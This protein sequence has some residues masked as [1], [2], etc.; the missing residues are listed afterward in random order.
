M[1]AQEVCLVPAVKHRAKEHPDHA[2][3]ADLSEAPIRGKDLPAD[4]A[5]AIG[6]DSLRKQV[7][8]GEESAFIKAAQT[9]KTLAIKEHEHACGER[10]E[11][12]TYALH[13]VAAEV[14]RV[15]EQISVTAGDADGNEVQLP[16]A[17]GYE[18]SS[19]QGAITQFDIGVK[20]EHKGG[21]GEPGASVAANRR[22]A[23]V[24]DLDGKAIAKAERE[25]C[26][27]VSRARIGKN[28]ARLGEIGDVLQ[29]KRLEQAGKHG[30]FVPGGDHDGEVCRHGEASG[31]L[32]PHSLRLSRPEIVTRT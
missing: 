5:E 30:R 10:F 32:Y 27:S 23:A 31:G 1:I 21:G 17:N 16:I 9:E 6:G 7:V 13:S 4:D 14:E 20:K 26:R 22:Q 3:V 18:R 11:E 12:R 28:N 2:A 8:F 19:K 25:L 15:V 24:C 29:Q